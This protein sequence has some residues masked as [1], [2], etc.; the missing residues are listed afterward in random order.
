MQG[1]AQ[2]PARQGDTQA[3]FLSEP[4]NPRAAPRVGGDAGQPALHA[5]AR[6]LAP[7]SPLAGLV[8]HRRAARGMLQQRHRAGVVLG[9]RDPQHNGRDVR[10][11]GERAH[12]AVRQLQRRQFLRAARRNAQLP[13]GC[14]VMSGFATLALR[15]R[16][17]PLL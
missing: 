5:A 13:T 17:K 10:V 7:R 8:A 2:Q 16:A 11:V 4:K 6:W 15:S 1:H 3:A 12:H 9:C 14:C